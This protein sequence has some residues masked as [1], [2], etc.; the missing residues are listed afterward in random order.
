[1]SSTRVNKFRRVSKPT[2]KAQRTPQGRFRPA[3]L[4]PDIISADKVLETDLD[5]HL[6]LHL[7]VVQ[8][9]QLVTGWTKG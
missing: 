2:P 1:M 6:D 9:Q 7:K 5:D 8:L 3:S 4:T